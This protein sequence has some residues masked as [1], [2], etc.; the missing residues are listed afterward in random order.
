MFTI[1]DYLHVINTASLADLDALFVDPAADCRLFDDP[2]TILTPGS[3]RRAE[4]IASL[5]AMDPGPAMIEVLNNLE[6]AAVAARSAGSA[7]GAGDGHRAALRG[8]HGTRAG[9]SVPA[10]D[11]MSRARARAYADREAASDLVEITAAWNRI[12]AWASAHTIANAAAL[13]RTAVMNPFWPMT[14]G[15]VSTLDVAAEELAMRL[16]CTR[17]AAASLVDVGLA[18]DDSLVATR[19]ALATGLIDMAKAKV[20]NR[21]LGALPDEVVLAV[22]NMVLPGAATRTTTQLARDI[23]KALIDVDPDAAETRRQEALGDRRVCRPKPLGD[24]MAGFW[25]ILPAVQAVQIDTALD[26]AARSLRSAGDARTLDQ[27]RADL[28]AYSLLHAA[29]PHAPSSTS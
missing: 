8:C 11:A 2:Q 5:E 23:E 16:G 10:G 29:C 22:E 27:L 25:A 7:P 3:A 15:K 9:S 14:S 20:F 1:D 12:G 6:S 26:T 21:H 19:T 4:A 13:S 28:F 17:A 18:L 24:G